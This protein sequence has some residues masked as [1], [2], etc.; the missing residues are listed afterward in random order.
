[1][2]VVR[3]IL[4][5]Q[6]EGYERLNCSR[7]VAPRELLPNE[8]T[9]GLSV[10]R[11]QASPI[12]R[13]QFRDRLSWHIEHGPIGANPDLEEPRDELRSLDRPGVEQPV[14]TI[15]V[16]GNWERVAGGSRGR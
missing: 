5:G 8:C 9:R 12:R 15:R 3:E 16:C 1:S 4:A 13:N 14:A 10:Y 2:R 11:I 6:I 7:E